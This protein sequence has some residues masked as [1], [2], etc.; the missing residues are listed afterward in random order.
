MNSRLIH[1]SSPFLQSHAKDPIDW[2]PWGNEALSKAQKSQKPLFVSLG[3]LSCHWC[4]AMGVQSFSNVEVAKLLNP[5]FICILI[6][7]DERPDLAKHFLKAAQVS[8]GHSGW[9]LNLF[10]TP[11]GSAYYGVTYLPKDSSKGMPG[12]LSIIPQAAR[13]WREK[14]DS[15]LKDALLV[16]KEVFKEIGSLD[17]QLNEVTQP[18]S[19][20]QKSFYEDLKSRYDYV[21][22]G[23]DKSPKFPNPSLLMSLSRPQDVIPTNE[24]SNMIQQTLRSMHSRGY[25]D[26]VG[27]GFYRYCMD[28]KWEYPHFEKIGFDNA[29]M[30]YL[31]MDCFK[32]YPHAQSI[33]FETLEFII[34]SL[35][36]NNGLFAHGLNA[37]TQGREGSFYLW[38]AEEIFNA[39]GTLDGIWFC[40]LMGFTP[41]GNFPNT[42]GKLD[43]LHHLNQLNVKELDNKEEQSLYVKCLNKLRNKRDIREKPIVEV[44]YTVESNAMI[45]I[46]LIQYGH[47]FNKAEWIQKGLELIDQIRNHRKQHS[48]RMVESQYFGSVTDYFDDGVY[49]SWALYKAHQVTSDEAYSNDLTLEINRLIEKFWDK[50]LGGFF[51]NDQSQTYP[52]QKEFHDTTYPSANSILYQLITKFKPEAYRDKADKLQQIVRNLDQENLSYFSFFHFNL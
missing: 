42:E 33:A 2:F 40:E 22:G 18:K 45:A 10:C 13:V 38:R 9:P 37:D 51:Y 47:E 49:Y 16:H 32:Y 39:L 29:W 3:Y 4:Q 14:K 11:E 17:N 34:N 35:Q 41:E 24:A 6:D 46:S 8:S 15:V 23:F 19:S 43:G 27:G 25:Y 31:Y 44:K 30:A 1:Q 20:L 12:L 52:Q 26:H 28:Q 7:K 48:S 50:K 5:N 21:N 36:Q